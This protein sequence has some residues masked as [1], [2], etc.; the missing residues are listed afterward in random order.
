MERRKYKPIFKRSDKK[1][2]KNYRPLSLTSILCKV[3]ESFLKDYLHDFL[4]ENNI[5]LNKKYGFLP[6]KST[7]FKLWNVSDK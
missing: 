3:M 5:L 2:P 4:H 1:D 7:I 6:D